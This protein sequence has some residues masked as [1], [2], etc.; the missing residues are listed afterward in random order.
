[1]SEELAVQHPLVMV[2]KGG[3]NRLKLDSV[4]SSASRASI[5]SDITAYPTFES[6]Q[7]AV[8]VCRQIE[9]DGVIAIGGGSVMDTAK[10]V[11]ASLGTGVTG[12]AELLE[13]HTP[14]PDRVRSIFI[15]TTHGTGSE[16]TMW[17]TI[18]NAGEKK[19]YSISHPDLYPHTAI[20]DPQLTLDLPLEISLMTALDA[21]SHS[22]EAVWNKNANPKSTAYAVRAIVMILTSVNS[23]KRNLRDLRVRQTLLKASNMAGLAFS[24]TRTAA[25]HS[26]SYPLTLQFGIPHGIA[27]SMPLGPLLEINSSK[28]RKDMDEI[29]EGLGTSEVSHLKDL[30]SEIPAGVL[31]FS[32]RDWGVAREALDDLGDQSF[33]KG[34]MDNNIVDLSKEDVRYVLERMY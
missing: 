3:L 9:C 16:V 23:L 30:I 6:C 7:Q 34:R 32:L 15:P 29:L 26:I 1:M 17:A 27:S 10:A 11:L 28:I 24:N 13:I 18:W 12:I 19:K 14:F 31:D 33:T 8:N 20:L 5:F 2:S 22:F 25:A 4:F 21:L